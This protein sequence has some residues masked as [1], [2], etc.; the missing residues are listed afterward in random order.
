M[1]KAVKLKSRSQCIWSTSQKKD[2]FEHKSYTQNPNSILSY[3]L[4]ISLDTSF[5]LANFTKIIKV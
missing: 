5:Y 1:T 2:H 4:R 3:I